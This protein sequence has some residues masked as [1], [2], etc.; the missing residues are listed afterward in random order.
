VLRQIIEQTRKRLGEL[1]RVATKQQHVDLLPPLTSAHTLERVG[2]FRRFTI[3]DDQTGLLRLD[4]PGE[5]Q[6]RHVANSESARAQTRN[7]SLRLG[8]RIAHEH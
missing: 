3:A 4:A 1:F 2:E 6:Q 8:G 7:Q 5:Q